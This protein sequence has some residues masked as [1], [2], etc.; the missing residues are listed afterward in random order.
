MAG[1]YKMIEVV[2]TSPVSFAEAVKSGIEEA[3]KSVHHM[4]WFEVVEMRGAIK[5]GKAAE[6]Q[7]T[8]KI[9]FRVER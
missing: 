7:V 9:G 6:F 3:G 1:I 4:N 2:G 5:D 8:L